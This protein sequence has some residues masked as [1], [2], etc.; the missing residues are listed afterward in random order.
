MNITRNQYYL[1]IIVLLLALGSINTYQDK[2]RISYLEEMLAENTAKN[3]LNFTD[4][5]AVASQAKTITADSVKEN[6]MMT[7]EE[8]RQ[9]EPR[10]ELTS[11]THSAFEQF[12]RNLNTQRNNSLKTSN[13]HDV[14]EN[15]SLCNEDGEALL[16]WLANSP[17]KAEQLARLFAENSEVWQDD[18]TLRLLRNLADTE[19]QQTL[20]DTLVDGMQGDHSAQYRKA[21]LEASQYLPLDENQVLVVN[22][23]LRSMTDPESIVESMNIIYNSVP[24]TEFELVDG[25]IKTVIPPKLPIDFSQ[26]YAHP[27]EEVRANALQAL[28]FTDDNSTDLF[29]E[30][31]FASDSPS[32]VQSALEV[33]SYAAETGKDVSTYSS[34]LIKLASDDDA[35][36]EQQHEA[37]SLL[38]KQFLTSNCAKQ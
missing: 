26:F 8:T 6:Q 20:V 23:Q 10:L 33:L 34:T 19:A 18:Q 9:N 14:S 38:G 1:V 21:L 37:L 35:N 29:L 12:C 22:D 4:K 15:P 7:N 30:E 32:V 36:Y 28:A 17:E 3:N 2:R 24:D 5:P 16:L 11:S 13:A 25:E 31:A 27:D